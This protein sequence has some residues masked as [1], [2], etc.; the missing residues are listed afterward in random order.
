MSVGNQTH[1][2]RAAHRDACR[3]RW[4]S[5]WW[6]ACLSIV[7]LFGG[8]MPAHAVERVFAQAHLTLDLPPEYEFGASFGG[9]WL[10]TERASFVANEIPASVTQVLPSM[11]R[12]GLASYGMTELSRNAVR[13]DG[14]DAWLIKVRQ[15]AEGIVFD[16]WL[17][18]MG[19]NAST[20]TLTASYPASRAA[21]FEDPMRR[22]LLAAHWN[23]AEPAG[24]Q[25]RTAPMLIRGGCQ[26]LTVGGV[27]YL[28]T[29]AAPKPCVL[30][31]TA[32]RPSSLKLEYPGAPT[33][34]VRLKAANQVAPGMFASLLV[35]SVNTV[36][37]NGGNCTVDGSRSVA[38]LNCVIGSARNERELLLS[39][40]LD[41]D[42]VY[43]PGQTNVEDF[44]EAFGT[45]FNAL[46]PTRTY[47][48]PPP[49]NGAAPNAM[50]ANASSARA[51]APV[52]TAQ[53]LTVF[54]LT[55]GKPF[56]RGL[57]ACSKEVR[58]LLGTGWLAEPSRQAP[59]CVGAT[60]GGLNR[61]PT[62]RIGNK[63]LI[64]V[65][66]SDALFARELL[67]LHEF[68][69]GNHAFFAVLDDEKKLQ[70]LLITSTK[71]DGDDVNAVIRMLT[72]RLKAQPEVV[73]KTMGSQSTGGDSVQITVPRWYWRSDSQVVRFGSPQDQP[74]ADA[75]QILI[76]TPEFA[77][78]LLPNG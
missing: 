46:A 25:A 57:P 12:A 32:G 39:F 38:A 49:G 23:V 11:D 30:Q 29:P 7:L 37:A 44:F 71:F 4:P 3:A 31:V 69:V 58:G 21:V 65:M 61:Q 67:A 41:D 10:P 47:V 20:V 78:E 68:L 75:V 15:A 16:K 74:Q 70:G 45:M 2:C 56:P 18:V 42:R 36:S 63:T 17:L 54:G 59:L 72:D 1:G 26:N 35:D 51:P 48:R 28:R 24:A 33:V 66:P 34:V 14:R 62:K 13:A 40:R 43:S 76:L 52:T 55:V 73:R 5:P 8:L 60:E 64:P 50:A 9:W 27:E 22:V 53:P 6:Q 19:T 77:R